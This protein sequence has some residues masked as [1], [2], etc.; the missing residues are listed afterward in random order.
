MRSFYA[1]LIA[2]FVSA[3][4]GKVDDSHPNSNE[5]YPPGDSFMDQTGGMIA[6]NGSGGS[7]GESS[8]A[9]AGSPSSTPS[10]GAASE[11]EAGGEAGFGEHAA[12]TGGAAG[13]A[14]SPSS[15]PSAGAAGETGHS[16]FSSSAAGTAVAT[17]GAEGSPV[18]G[19][20]GGQDE[21]PSK[22]GDAA[23]SGAGGQ[24]GESSIGGAGGSV[25]TSAETGV[26]GEGGSN[27]PSTL[28]LEIELASDTPETAIVIP[29]VNYPFTKY[30]VTNPNDTSVSIDRF[31][32][33][34]V[35][36]NGEIADFAAVRVNYVLDGEWLWS[37]TYTVYP[38]GDDLTRHLN[39]APL[40]FGNTNF[41]VPANG[42]IELE[43]TGL[44]SIPLAPKTAGSACD[45]IPC[46]GEMP[47]L[48]LVNVMDDNG[49]RA[50]VQDHDPEPM[51]LRKARPRIVSL[52]LDDSLV[53]DGVFAQLAHWQVIAQDATI[54]WKSMR[55]SI[56]A[57]GV[58]SL[59]DL[60]LYKESELVSDVRLLAH[61]NPSTEQ[62]WTAV[63][64]VELGSE[65]VVTNSGTVYS[66]RA[67][68]TLTDQNATMTVTWTR[69]PHSDDVS[70]TG[71]LADTWTP[72]TISA[73][74]FIDE[75][76]DGDADN[77]T[78]FLWSDM[79]EVPHSD[80]TVLSGGSMDWISD[81]GMNDI[82]EWNL[83]S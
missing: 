81:W 83:S 46:S 41:M 22:G 26:S 12:E 51:V 44:M 53:A 49:V 27:I 28:P 25:G 2:I 61:A 5:C 66:L 37:I 16:D 21:T 63:L 7:A 69:N 14:G 23:I 68:P 50:V 4:G 58:S 55:F 75:D 42:Q 80:A 82:F 38:V 9:Q 64:T 40:P 11:E 70:V 71:G 10:A 34:E 24:A 32:V 77:A 54:A 57:Y 31:D 6:Q 78:Y 20:S 30:V 1:I 3:C 76:A 35:S 73:A 39:R 8:A 59:Q 79:S 18:T 47:A 13:E 74:I 52:P 56:D 62:T 48:K 45:G 19:G 17:A 15:T 65:D 29:S 43:I 60:Q 33:D 72:G 67:V 36:P